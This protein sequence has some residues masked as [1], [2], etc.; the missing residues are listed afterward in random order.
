MKFSRPR[1]LP[2]F[3]LEKL[4]GNELRDTIEIARV[5][6]SY[7][8]KKVLLVQRDKIDVGLMDLCNTIS[9]KSAWCS[10]N[11]VNCLIVTFAKYSEKKNL[12][13]M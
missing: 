2:M 1:L 6:Q 5:L 9:G 3:I 10:K 8:V 4:F 13:E 12:R 7:S 11:L